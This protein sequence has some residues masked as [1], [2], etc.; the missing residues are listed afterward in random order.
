MTTKFGTVWAQSGHTRHHAED[1]SQSSAPRKQRLDNTENTMNADE[2]IKQLQ[3]AI[4]EERSQVLEA[5]FPETERATF[6]QAVTN[7]AT[8]N[9]MGVL[10]KLNAALERSRCQPAAR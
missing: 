10:G 5:L 3:E 2:M 8:I 6:A 1:H 9:A 4:D 7:A